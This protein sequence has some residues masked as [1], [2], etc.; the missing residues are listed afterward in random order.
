MIF[1]IFGFETLHK[2]RNFK[3]KND[4]AVAI[5]ANNEDDFQF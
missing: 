5:I 1:P 2:K 3:K 4:T